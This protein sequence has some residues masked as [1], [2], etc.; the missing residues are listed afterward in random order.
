MVAGKTY[1]A[2][3]NHYIHYGLLYLCWQVVEFAIK[4]A[5]AAIS[6]WT[7]SSSGLVY[8]VNP[9]YLMNTCPSF[10]EGHD[11]TL[12]RCPGSPLDFFPSY[13]S[14]LEGE[15]WSQIS[16]KVMD[17]LAV[18]HRKHPELSPSLSAAEIG[19]K[20]TSDFRRAATWTDILQRYEA[21][22]VAWSA[23]NKFCMDR[24]VIMTTYRDRVS[25]LTHTLMYSIQK[26]VTKHLNDMNLIFSVHKFNGR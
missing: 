3:A 8:N 13:I 18:M 20:H 9:N 19:L 16:P 24:V 7:S 10:P 23:Y 2:P 11:L 14:G 21:I 4:L 6:I 5:A 12:S 17:W 25:L 1:L 26:T 22:A 15:P